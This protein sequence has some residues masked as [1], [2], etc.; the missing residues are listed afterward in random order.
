MKLELT[1]DEI[2]Y[3]RAVIRYFKQSEERLNFD[4]YFGV[5]QEEIFRKLTN[6]L[7]PHIYDYIG[8]SRQT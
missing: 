2:R 5:N 6:Q 4:Q 8:E 1:F 7:K 3:V